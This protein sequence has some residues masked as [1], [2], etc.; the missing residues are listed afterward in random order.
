VKPGD[1]GAGEEEPSEEPAAVLF[2]EWIV[3]GSGCVFA[4]T[5]RKKLVRV[6]VA[7]EPTIEDVTDLE[8]SIEAM[9]SRGKVASCCFPT[10]EPPVGIVELVRVLRARSER[11]DVEIR[12]SP[13]ATDSLDVAVYWKRGDGERSS[14]LGTAPHFCMPPTRRAPYLGMVVWAG[15]RT[16]NGAF[17]PGPDVGLIDIPL[18]ISDDDAI[19]KKKEMGSRMRALY[20]LGFAERQP[21]HSMT[22][23]LRKADAPADLRS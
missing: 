12:A 1:D 6:V 18:T 14:V 19:A 13:I 23:R 17:S 22:F 11:W 16:R 9:A 15:P 10:V 4:R 5:I 2:G 20:E 8:L 21:L 7:P 3:G